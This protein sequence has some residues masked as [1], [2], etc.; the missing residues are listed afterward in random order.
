MS[1]S[2][3]P[4]IRRSSCFL[5]LRGPSVIPEPCEARREFSVY[6]SLSPYVYLPAP[7]RTRP[8][9]QPSNKSPETRQARLFL[10][11]H[12][13]RSEHSAASVVS[14]T[15]PPVGMGFTQPPAVWAPACPAL[16]SADSDF[17]CCFAELMLIHPSKGSTK[18]PFERLS[19]RLPRLLCTH[20]F[21]APSAPEKT[22]L[23]N[24]HTGLGF[25]HV[26]LLGLM[27]N[28]GNR[29]LGLFVCLSP[30]VPSGTLQLLVE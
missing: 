25:Q 5:G 15:P 8:T 23:Q 22:P 6:I 7:D 29:P 18:G 14:V 16:P 11:A 9:N 13:Y 10:A 17:S 24:L 28:A 1:T 4:G 26:W 3:H 19:E 30:W 21:W 27:Q 2:L 20:H 12:K